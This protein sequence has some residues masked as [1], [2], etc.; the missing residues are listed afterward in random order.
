MPRVARIKSSTG[1]YHLI[2][3]GFN[4]QNIFSS[5]VVNICKTQ[6]KALKYLKELNGC[7][8]RQLAR[9]TGLA[10]HQIRRF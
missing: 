9:L 5:D 1:I 10:L 7:S 4:Q 6:Q 8:L 2:N 3:R